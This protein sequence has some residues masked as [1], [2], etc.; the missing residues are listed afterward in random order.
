MSNAQKLLQEILDNGKK[1]NS[2]KQ[3][4]NNENSK[5]MDEFA[6]SL[7]QIHDNFA[8]LD[9]GLQFYQGYY[10]EVLDLKNKIDDY[11]IAR[12][13]ERENMIQLIGE[14]EKKNDDKKKNENAEESK[15][16]FDENSLSFPMGKSVFIE[17]SKVNDKQENKDE[18]KG[19]NIFESTIISQLNLDDKK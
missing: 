18:Y 4:P 19:Q 5:I 15:P 6:S 3:N 8:M 17:G 2:R 7:N 1:L 14:N 9:F 10:P 16:F 13:N 11:C 12:K